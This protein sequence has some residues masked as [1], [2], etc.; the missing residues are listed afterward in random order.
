MTRPSSSSTQNMRPPGTF[1]STRLGAS[2]SAYRP[3]GL[4]NGYGKSLSQSTNQIPRGHS[5][6]KSQLTHNRQIPA[7]QQQQDTVK[8]PSHG[9]HPLTISSY[10]QRPILSQTRYSSLNFAPVIASRHEFYRSSSAPALQ[11]PVFSVP[12]VSS[13]VSITEK[14]DETSEDSS[15]ISAFQTKLALCDNDERPSSETSKSS[16]SQATDDVFCINHVPSAQSAISTSPKRPKKGSRIPQLSPPKQ[17]KPEMMCGSPSQPKVPKKTPMNGLPSKPPFLTK[18]S[19][20]THPDWDSNGLESRLKMME[21]IF[22]TM[23]GQMDG[24]S[25]ERSSTK[26]LI[27]TM[28]MRS[29]SDDLNC[30]GMY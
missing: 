20:L 3:T 13:L 4:S 15:L 29:T 7:S 24:T 26:E 5:R 1:A 11:P 17:P 21:T 19:N 9:M 30:V 12:T 25:F 23:K 6:S 27:E 16:I 14:E 2:T 28:K 22:H 18:D 10:S 8:E